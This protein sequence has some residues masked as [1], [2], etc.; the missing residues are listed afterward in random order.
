MTQRNIK[1]IYF[2]Q[3]TTIESLIRTLSRL[4]DKIFNTVAKAPSVF[5]FLSAD[6]RALVLFPGFDS[7]DGLNS[8]RD[9]LQDWQLP[10]LRKWDKHGC[11]EKGDC[12]EA[13]GRGLVCL[14]IGSSHFLYKI[15]G[16]VTAESEEGAYASEVQSLLW[17]L[18]LHLIFE[19]V[20]A[21]RMKGE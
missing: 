10:R 7:Q 13:G 6:L 4:P 1:D 18:E 5:P 14:T 9:C 2:F 15:G 8:S 20:S 16:K 3:S 17:T 11:R 19:I 12:M 21:G